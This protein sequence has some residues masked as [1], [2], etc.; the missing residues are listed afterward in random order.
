MN[1]GTTTSIIQDY[2]E[3]RLV[4]LDR[5]EF[6]RHID[7]CAACERELVSLRDVFTFLAKMEPFEVPHGFQNA[8]ISQ[9][10]SEGHVHEPKVAPIRRWVAVF[11]GLPGVAKYPLAALAVVAA[12]YLPLKLA[13]MAAGGVVGRMT[14][15]VTDLLVSARDTLAG[16]AFLTGLWDVLSG[17]VRAV[18]TVFGACLS[19]LNTASESFWFVGAGVGVVL[20]AILLAARFL[21]KRSTNNAPLSL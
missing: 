20:A 6:L 21:K 11:V 5:S 9:L 7:Q 12:V 13:L 3:R 2:L 15:A 17:Y 18:Q 8:I 10:K 1:C 16:A 19:L 14:V 4:Q